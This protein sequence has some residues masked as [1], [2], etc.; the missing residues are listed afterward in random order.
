MSSSIL[1][2]V[3]IDIPITAQQPLRVG[4]P[5]SAKVD[6]DLSSKGFGEATCNEIQPRLEGEAEDAE[7]DE[8][9]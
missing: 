5:G 4:V 3:H 6:L 8:A 2:S 7:D 1:T 9:A